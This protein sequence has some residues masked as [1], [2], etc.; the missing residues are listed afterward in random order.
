MPPKCQK[1]SDPSAWVVQERATANQSLWNKLQT[2]LSAVC[3]LPGVQRWWVWE[4][5]RSV[6]ESEAEV[7]VTGQL[8]LGP[9]WNFWQKYLTK[10]R[11]WQSLDLGRMVNEELP[12]VMVNPQRLGKHSHL[13]RH[14]TRGKLESRKQGVRGGIHRVC[15]ALL[16][17]G[18]R[19]Q[20]TGQHKFSP[21]TY[22]L[23]ARLEGS[24]EEKEKQTGREVCSELEGG[25][26]RPLRCLSPLGRQVFS[27]E[28]RSQSWWNLKPQVCGG[29]LAFW[30]PQL[31]QAGSSWQAH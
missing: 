3:F 12:G 10:K 7:L 8:S 26:P 24:Q 9:F 2:V 22:I 15:P 21:F 6:T 29:R 16:C 5:Q 31:S 4:S 13:R 30:A 27:F 14:H 1:S 28:A 25:Q 18:G 20:G 17:S 23:P 19:E 11:S